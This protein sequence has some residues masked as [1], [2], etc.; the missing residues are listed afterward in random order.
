MRCSFI[1]PVFYIADKKIKDAL[2]KHKNHDL[3]KSNLHL[4]RCFPFKTS[5]LLLMVAQIAS[6]K[7]K[8]TQ[9]F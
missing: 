9:L 8:N 5:F 7:P 1:F 4:N 6:V 3:L 2:Q